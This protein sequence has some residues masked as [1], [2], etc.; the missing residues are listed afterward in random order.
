MRAKMRRWFDAKLTYSRPS[1]CGGGEDSM[2]QHFMH[3]GMNRHERCA[4]A[5]VRQF[6]FLACATAA[7]GAA[8]PTDASAAKGPRN[9]V[10][11]ARPAAT[12]GRPAAPFAVRGTGGPHAGLAVPQAHEFGHPPGAPPG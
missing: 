12:A 10:A 5:I 6:F 3:Q 1:S 2:H 8:W 4:S 9:A 7:I 11:A